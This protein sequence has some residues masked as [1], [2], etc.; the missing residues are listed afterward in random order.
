MKIDL[1]IKNA[2]VFNTVKQCF[3]TKYVTVSGSKFYYITSKDVSHLQVEQEIDGRGKYLIPGL[4][5]SHMHIESSMTTPSI[6][7]KAVLPFGVTTVIADAH[8][9]ANV[10]GIDGLT[11]FMNAETELDIFHAIPSS[12][13]STT[14]ELETTGGLIGLDETKTL[15]AHPKVICLGEA[16]NFHGIAHEPESLI[17]QIIELCKEQRPT[18]PLEGHCPKIYEEELAAFMYSGISS[19]HTHQFPESL[20]EKI[21]N[22]MFIQF[23]NK[24]ITPENMAVITENEYYDYSCLITDDV[25]ADDLLEGHLNENLKKAVAAGLPI[26]KAIYMTTYT[27]ARRMG[28]N[29]R[30]LIGP[31]R[32]ADFILLDDL[33][34]FSIAAVYKSG[35]QVYR[36]G[37]AVAYPEKI[38][39]FPDSYSHT[40]HCKKLTAKDLQLRVGTELSSVRCNVIRKYEVGT[41]TERITKE[42]P[43]KDGYL[44]WENSDCALLVVMERYGKNGNIA[45]ALMEQPIS[46]KGSI[47]TTW[48]HDHHNVM[49]MGNNSEDILLAQQ[50]LLELQGGYVVVNDG[51]V[52]ASC[53][54]PIGGIVSQAPIEELGRDLQKVRQGMQDLGYKNMNEIMS[55]STLSLPVSPTIKMTDKGMMNTK[56]QEFY[57]LIFPED[58][59][60]LCVR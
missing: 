29:D 8:E 6:F 14:P 53:P 18:M 49:V 32:L 38:E 57:P 19:D 28:L 42:I 2:Q 35:K 39:Q 24:S 25:M 13:P 45:Y 3:E 21:E 10:F 51:S 36:K 9:M 47:A 1:L 40:V 4:I 43:V 22:G 44:D 26:E 5:D 48:A 50:K 17:R 27:P 16:M 54:L 46:Q 11:E 55:F 12:V 60:V 59:A 58:G 52:V 23:Q 56:T 15:L 33:E 41:F 30:G 7:S 34:T 31:G 37:V 20:A